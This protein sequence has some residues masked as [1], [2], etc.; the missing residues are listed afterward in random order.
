MQAKTP[1]PAP[2][3]AP[4]RWPLPLPNIDPASAPMAPPSAALHSCGVSSPAVASVWPVGMT[5]PICAQPLTSASTHA[6][7]SSLTPR[8][9]KVCMTSPSL[10]DRDVA[11]RLLLR[12]LRLPQQAFRRRI[13]GVHLQR[14]LGIGDR[15]RVVLL[16][17][18]AFAFAQQ[19]RR[20]FLH[21]VRL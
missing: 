6:A 10:V 1:M 21:A 4:A 16:A 14:R 5:P 8:I 17:E 2:I 12:L 9:P 13:A 19:A 20:H 15:R 7:P 11:H 3:A 18:V